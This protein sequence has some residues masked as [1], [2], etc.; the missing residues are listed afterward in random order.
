M[1]WTGCDL[2]DVVDVTLRGRQDVVLCDTE[3]A[4]DVRMVL[5]E[6]KRQGGDS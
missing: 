1:G 4:R 6:Q 2:L 5:C 3:E